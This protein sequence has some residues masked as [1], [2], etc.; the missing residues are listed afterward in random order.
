[1][2]RIKRL[3][4]LNFQ[5]SI[6]VS[7]TISTLRMPAAFACRAGW[8]SGC[9]GL[10]RDQPERVLKVAQVT[11][12]AGRRLHCAHAGEQ[13]GNGRRL[14]VR[15]GHARPWQVATVAGAVVVA[16]PRVNGRR[17]DKVSGEWARF[18]SQNLPP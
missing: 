5:G 15:N 9:A 1:M 7:R 4:R 13:D 11:G 6:V 16:A 8:R 3:S 18:R 12:V 17:A 2:S 10:W 14:L